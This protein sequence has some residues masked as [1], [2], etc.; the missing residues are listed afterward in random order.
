MLITKVYVKRLSLVTLVMAAML[1]PAPLLAQNS[2]AT[3][4]DLI[5]GN[6]REAALGRISA[7]EDVNAPQPDGTRPIHWAVYRVDYELLEALIANDADPNVI[8]IFGSTPIAQAAGIGDQLEAAHPGGKFGFHD[9][10]RRD[11]GIGL[12]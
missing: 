2:D 3:L 10:D 12:M 11:A 9:L 6:V 7:G 1:A 5:E 4:A 8:N